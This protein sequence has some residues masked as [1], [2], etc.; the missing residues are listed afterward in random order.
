LFIS[1]YTDS[2]V[3]VH[4]MVERGTAFLNKPYTEDELIAKVREVLDRSSGQLMQ[5]TVPVS[6]AR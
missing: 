2:F 1:G 6:D 3:A 5:N 4:G